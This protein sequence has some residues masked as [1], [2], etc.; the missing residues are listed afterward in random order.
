MTTQLP[1]TIRAE[2][3][4]N[5][6]EHVTS[7][8]DATTMQ[9]LQEV[10]QN[11]RRSGATEIAITT[12][13]AGRMTVRDNGRG[14]A[15]PRSLL[16]FGTSRWTQSATRREQP[17]GMGTYALARH[18][19]RVRS[20]TAGGGPG[21][22]TK[23]RQEHFEG[24]TAAAVRRSDAAPSPHG[25]EVHFSTSH[26]AHGQ[27]Y[28][29]TRADLQW[30]ATKAARHLKV[31]ITLDGKPVEQDDFLHGSIATT[32]W[33]GIRLG[34]IR[35][36][37]LNHAMNF[38]GIL[39]KCPMPRVATLEWGLT[40]LADVIDSDGL[41]LVLPGRERV[42]ENRFTEELRDAA[43][44]LIYDTLAKR[45]RSTDPIRVPYD[46]AVD[47]AK[48]GFEIAPGTPALEPI[49][50]SRPAWHAR[51]P[52]VGA[53]RTIYPG[54][55]LVIDPGPRSRVVTIDRAI[56]DSGLDLQLYAAN[57]ALRGY[58]WYDAL[59]IVEDMTVVYTKDGQT[60]EIRPGYT[61]TGDLVADEIQLVLHGRRA[62]NRQYELKLPT[63]VAFG[64]TT[65]AYRDPGHCGLIVRRDAP[66]NASE[67]GN[68]AAEALLIVN[69]DDSGGRPGDQVIAFSRA[70]AC[71]DRK[72]RISKREAQRHAI[73]EAVEDETTWRCPAN[74]LVEIE[75]LD[76]VPRVTAVTSNE[77]PGR[78]E[79]AERSE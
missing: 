19:A 26:R 13:D 71:T 37:E 39:C 16:G 24:R 29:P 50:L 32:I 58:E 48:R 2:I 36:M 54:N 64:R 76:G 77:T 1:D 51:D 79:T 9:T 63:D 49:D 35:G 44:E 46:V 41:E 74:G 70:V 72:L 27:R 21:W 6:M 20:R 66:Q 28:T 15:D 14:I 31:R 78:N 42:I 52:R 43:T 62:G 55:P 38:H 25:T 34:V 22:E 3:H 8:F 33:R 30:T 12:D 57:G 17:A 65:S 61:E 45:S 23:L 5:A 18:G 60:H 10:L 69:E 11:A 59:P 4:A 40:T 47:A 73:L 75:I 67:I 56:R 53:A 68:M 7:F